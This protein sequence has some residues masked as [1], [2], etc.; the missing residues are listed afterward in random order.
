MEKQESE[1]QDK[2]HGFTIDEYVVL[3]PE[4]GEFIEETKDGHLSVLVDIYKKIDN[5]MIKVENHEVTPDLQNKI[6]EY[7]NR[8]LT[9]AIENEKSE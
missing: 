3:F 7:I 2:R 6:E 9:S 5:N 1:L 8:M 4:E